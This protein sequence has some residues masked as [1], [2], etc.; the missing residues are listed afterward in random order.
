[1]SG[2]AVSP[3]VEVTEDQ[4]LGGR[5]VMRQPRHGYRA[6]LDAVLLAAACPAVA[7]AGE[8]CLDCGAGA[9]VA[10]LAAAERVKDLR[11]TLVE[12]QPALAQMAR[13]NAAANSLAER[14]RVVADDLTRPLSEMA[15]LAAEVGQ[16]DHVIA[17]PPYH[18]HGAGTRA[19]DAMKDGSH[20]MARGAFEAW[21][22]FAA[23]MARSGGSFTIV[24][25][26]EVLG[27]VLAALERR[28]GRVTILPLHGREEQPASR[29]LVQAVKASRA[30]LRI[31]PG[32]VLHIAGSHA[33]TP[34]FDAI[35]RHGAALSLDR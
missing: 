20:A 24:Q 8:R 32:R 21:A 4:F 30:A 17:N 22:K 31:L 29:V 9:G 34:Q 15:A 14:C 28:F 35:L 26:P 19:T 11:V 27:E 18:A 10:G 6:G 7:G 2:A 1:M 5:L 13:Y 3:D 16:F 23:G 33:F 12:R 25:K